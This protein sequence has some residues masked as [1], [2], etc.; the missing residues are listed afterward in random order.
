MLDRSIQEALD[1]LSGKLEG[2]TS[3]TE[4]SR[5]LLRKQLPPSAC[6]EG[7]TLSGESVMADRVGFE[8]TVRF[9]ARQFSRLLP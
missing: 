3:N 2:E 8:P 1:S 9:H 5:G 7:V 4:G 6:R